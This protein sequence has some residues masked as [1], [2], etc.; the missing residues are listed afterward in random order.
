[1]ELRDYQKQALECS[2]SAL[3]KDKINPLIVAAT[4][5]GKSLMIASLIDRMTSMWPKLRVICLASSMELI[6]QNYDKFQLISNKKY[7]SGIV[8]SKLNRRDTDK[9]IIFGSIKSVL[10]RIYEIGT[11]HLIIIDE[12]HLI[13]FKKNSE[14]RKAISFFK[15]KFDRVKFVGYT[16]TP[17]REKEGYIIG[18]ENSIFDDIV[19]EYNIGDA[20]KNGYLCPVTNFSSKDSLDM[21]NVKIVNND[22]CLSQ[23]D[24]MISK[25]LNIITPELISLIKSRTS[26]IIFVPQKNSCNLLSKILTEN[27]ISNHTI[28]SD[29][30]YER[31]LYID[32]FKKGQTKVLININ[33]LTTGF[34]APN[35]DLIIILRPT[36]SKVNYVQMVGR[37]T[38]LFPN[39][40]N[41]LIGDFTGTIKRL[42][43]IDK[44]NFKNKK[45]KRVKGENTITKI[46]INEQCL[47][48]LH[49]SVR[50]CPC[51]GREQPLKTNINNESEQEVTIL[52]T[53]IPKI[54]K[55]TYHVDYMNTY[56]HTS[57][58]KNKSLKLEFIVKE[59]KESIYIYLCF[60]SHH[61][62]IKTL[63]ET[64][65]KLMHGNEPIPI[66]STEAYNRSIE[67]KKPITIDVF[68][69][70]RFHK[71]LGI[72]YE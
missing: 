35:V 46:C 39:K 9:D 8:C 18:H 58:K 30:G 69:E 55:R 43:S 3:I 57:T 53:E 33:C 4:G 14:Y 40:K 34:D 11:R 19:F 70:N 56:L 54:R 23:S 44:L 2:S 5:T 62:Y 7:R 45:E 37:G 20:I 64:I 61:K 42:G 51:C 49:P 17:Y 60:S 59:R 31:S 32:R 36:K 28:T 67:L 27:S 41:C 1:M 22:Y 6:S 38:R 72:T 16:A 12:A 24:R 66:N 26:T 13:P 48:V 65:W 50:I 71:L 52:S 15:S 21:L 68:K 63:S 47:S 29:T 25:A 10:N